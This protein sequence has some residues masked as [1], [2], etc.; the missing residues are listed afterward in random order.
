[1]PT[2]PGP[3]SPMPA[4]EELSCDPGHPYWSQLLAWVVSG[5]ADP[6][7]GELEAWLQVFG[8]GPLTVAIR[9][10]PQQL[11]TGELWLGWVEELVTGY[12]SALHVRQT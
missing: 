10:M 12:W 5:P 4:P 8:E 11:L 7:R 6:P 1:M 2:H 9:G 3:P